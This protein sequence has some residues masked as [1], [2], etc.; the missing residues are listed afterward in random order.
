MKT[1]SQSSPTLRSLAK[2]VGPGVGIIGGGSEAFALRK[3]F[4]GP[5]LEMHRA[6]ITSLVRLIVV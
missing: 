2:G 5:K 4:L 3:I 1:M 6:T